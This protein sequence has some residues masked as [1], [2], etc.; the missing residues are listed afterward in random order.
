MNNVIDLHPVETIEGEEM[1]YT[2]DNLIM[3]LL[4]PDHPPVVGGR[5]MTDHEI[6]EYLRQCV[7]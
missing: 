1:E 2:F 7:Y 6:V 5:E 3:A 4:N